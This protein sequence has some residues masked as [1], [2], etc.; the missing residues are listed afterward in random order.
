MRRRNALRHQACD[1]NLR[2]FEASF[3]GN[4]ISVTAGARLIAVVV[5][6]YFELE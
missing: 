6:N 2:E 3:S 5:D 1:G 4:D